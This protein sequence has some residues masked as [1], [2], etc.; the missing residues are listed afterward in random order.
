M[1]VTAQTTLFERTAVPTNVIPFPNKKEKNVLRPNLPNIIPISRSK[2]F[3]PTTERLTSAGK[4]KAQAADRLT[5]YTMYRRVCDHLLSKGMV[6]DWSMMMIGI[7]TGLRV[8][9][10]VKLRVGHLYEEDEYGRLVHRDYI[11]LYE[12]KTGKRTKGNDDSVFITEAIRQASDTLIRHYGRNGIQLEYDDHLFRSIRP[13]A[14]GEYGMAA[15]SPH[16][17]F[18]DVQRALDL[19]INFGSHTFRKTFASIHNLL[20]R[21]IA[22]SSAAALEDT[23]RALRHNNASDTM[24]YLGIMENRS[25][26][27]REGVSD[28]LLGNGHFENLTL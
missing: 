6:R 19:K 22:G 24:R 5:S 13:G 10:L 21:E 2:M 18:K 16:R 1:N 9:D 28:W 20:A 27:L 3:D 8:S 7:A 26:M 17:I 15:N 14:N 4:P 12:K 23:Q 11:D 25:R